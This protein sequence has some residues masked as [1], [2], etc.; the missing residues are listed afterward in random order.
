[1][2]AAPSTC[3]LAC[4]VWA[5]WGLKAV[6]AWGRT[7]Q[8]LLPSI[9]HQD[10][11]K[12]LHVRCRWE[13]R[14]LRWDSLSFFSHHINFRILSKSNINME[15]ILDVWLYWRIGVALSWFHPSYDHR[16]D[17]SD[18]TFMNQSWENKHASRTTCWFGCFPPSSLVTP[19]DGQDMRYCVNQGRSNLLLAFIIIIIFFCFSPL[20]MKSKWRRRRRI[21]S[22]ISFLGLLSCIN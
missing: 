17:D 10:T 1:M 13:E 9:C 11:S 12:H 19:S 18:P 4:K 20:L 21:L 6:L 16:T 8:L 22:W 15:K 14:S 2:V 7:P 3:L 5:W